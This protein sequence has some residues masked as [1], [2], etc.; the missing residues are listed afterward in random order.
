MVSQSNYEDI[1]ED[2]RFMW[3]IESLN[4][5]KGTDESDTNGY[6]NDDEADTSNEEDTSTEAETNAVVIVATRSELIL[7]LGIEEMQLRLTLFSALIL[8][9]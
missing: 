1:V 6:T 8:Y 4:S 7:E 5:C 9:L 2:K 3:L